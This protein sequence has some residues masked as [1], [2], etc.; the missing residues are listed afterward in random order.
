MTERSDDYAT[1]IPVAVP[2]N[3]RRNIDQDG[4]PNGDGTSPYINQYDT[5]IP[6]AVRNTMCQK[7]GIPYPLPEM[8][9]F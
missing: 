6:N 5:T 9:V 4:N 3:T 7:C 8:P 2:V 1:G